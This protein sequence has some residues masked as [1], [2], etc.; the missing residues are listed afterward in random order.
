MPCALAPTVLTLFV[1]CELLFMVPVPD[2]A[3]AV[4]FGQVWEFADEELF[5]LLSDM[6]FLL[7]DGHV[8]LRSPFDFSRNWRWL[9]DYPPNFDLTLL[10]R[11]YFKD[12]ELYVGPF[13]VRDNGGGAISNAFKIANRLVD[14]PSAVARQRF[15]NGPAHDAFTPFE[16]I[17]IA[18][19]AEG[20][21]WVK[22]FVVLTNGW[23]LR[24]SAHQYHT[25]DEFAPGT[26][27]VEG[28]LPPDDRVD[29]DEALSAGPDGID[30]ILEAALDYVRGP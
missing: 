4:I 5:T 2:S 17:Q 18:P 10:E 6:L 27:N 25:L 11:N 15:K 23:Y 30:T 14:E 24:V 29:L 28:G 22:P 26:T 8:N 3:A 20:A 13:V 12:A 21:R 19:P 9:L 7:R 16:T 1:S